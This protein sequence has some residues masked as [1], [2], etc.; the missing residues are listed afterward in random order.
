VRVVGRLRWDDWTLE[1]TTVIAKCPTK[2]IGKLHER[3]D[4]FD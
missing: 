1:A 2:G 3:L 4:T